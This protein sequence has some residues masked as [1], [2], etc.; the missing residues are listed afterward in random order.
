MSNKSIRIQTTPGGTDKYVTV[1]LEND[2]DFFEILS[3][4]I[5]QK[6]LYGTF[7]ADYGVIVGRV[8]ANGGIGI[9]NAK[10]SVF[11]PITDEDK[12][13][14]EIT[15]IYPYTSPRDKNLDG[16]KYNLLPRVAVN[17]P[18]LVIGSYAPA[19]PVG[20]FPTKEEV[21]TNST[22]LEVYEKYYKFTTVTNQSGDYMI[23]GA[24]I[25]IQTVHMSV[26]VTDIGQ[27]SMTPATMISQL[28]YSPQLFADNKVK[29][30]TDLDNMPNV[31]T[32]NISVD[33]RPFWGD[34]EN[35][36][37]GITRQDFKIRATLVTSVTVFGAGF[38][39]NYDAVW[40]LDSFFGNRDDSATAMSINRSMEAEGSTRNEGVKFNTGIA[41]RRNA[42]FKIEVYTIPNRISDAD[43]ASGNFDTQ[44]D[45][46][47]ME[48]NEYSEILE[49][50]M[51]IITLP[52]NRTKK[53][54]DEF[55]NLIPTTDNDPNGIFTEFYGM[56]IIDYGVDTTMFNNPVNKPRD[57]RERS[58][59]ARLKIPQNRLGTVA[60]DSTFTSERPGTIA[61][62]TVE[63]RQA[64]NENW[65]KEVFKFSGGKLYSVAKYNAVSFETLA[66]GWSSNN[67]GNN[68]WRNAGNVASLTTT[69]DA[70]GFAY[71][72]TATYAKIGNGGDETL[73]NRPVFG[74]EWLNFCLYFPQIYNYTSG[75][76]DTT[77]LLSSDFG[78]ATDMTI[79][80]PYRVVGFR[81]DL[82][83]FLRSDIHRSTFIEVP[84]ADL[85]NIIQTVPDQ[86]G[87]T[88]QQLTTP[89]LTGTYPGTTGT[90]YFFK[91]L[92][93]ANIIEFLQQNGIIA[94]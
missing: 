62:K 76:F 19:V 53:I 3:L 90:K 42:P 75:V 55:G 87:F 18:F 74:A 43:V 66:D 49:D 71:N 68:I 15:A 86:K 94:A 78:S 27:Y 44:N 77:R 8:I 70:E 36:E 25:G 4:K 21:T 67:I 6:D 58:D 83:Y 14:P 2:V 20:T 1:K 89:P 26:D 40:G 64:L 37:I 51:F 61:G 28:G 57:Q 45:I 88:S 54:V 30:T 72:A 31:D 85:V 17:N 56:F 50:G 41:S 73:N 16:V 84:P 91:G 34:S 10:V 52:C 69:D 11:I 12:S 93:E 29:F 22:Y 38:T 47:K 24:P 33:V 35:F 46:V 65:R 82:S 80:N 5:S 23:F 48:T 32:Q 81:T 79:K 9:P 7:N 13:N 39:D 59:R 60:I 92:K 63:Q